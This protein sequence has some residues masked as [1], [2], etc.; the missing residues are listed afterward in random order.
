MASTA[1]GDPVLDWLRQMPPEVEY[2]ASEGPAVFGDDG[3][4]SPPAAPDAADVSVEI[5]HRRHR[6]HPTWEIPPVAGDLFPLRAAAMLGR[7]LGHEPICA[8]IH[9]LRPGASARIRSDHAVG[10]LCHALEGGCWAEVDW[11][12][13]E[14]GPEVWTLLLTRR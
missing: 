9:A 1:T 5:V 4:G 13:E 3:A 10:P 14:S 8:I 7:G 6:D 12:L 2:R 11:R